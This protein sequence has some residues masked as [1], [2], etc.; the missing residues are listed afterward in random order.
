MSGLLL[1]SKSECC[2]RR[3]AAERTLRCAVGGRCFTE[4]TALTGRI[5][6]YLSGRSVFQDTLQQNTVQLQHYCFSQDSEQ[7]ELT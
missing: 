2:G 5:V 4:M 6:S 1:V 3:V 7:T